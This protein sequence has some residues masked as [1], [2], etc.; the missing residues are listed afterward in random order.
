MTARS[1]HVRAGALSLPAPGVG[2][3]L[4]VRLARLFLWPVALATGGA[5]AALIVRA[6]IADAPALTA[7]VGLVVGLSWCLTG[8]EEWRRRPAR[9]IGPLML[10]FGFAWFASF[11]IYTSVS[12]LYTAG[13]LV[14]PLFIAVLGHLL[15]AFP[16]GRLE[17]RLSRAIIAAAYLD[18]T[19]VVTASALFLAPESGEVQNLG[20][21]EP[22]AALSDALRNVARGVGIALI[23]ASLL[24]LARR[25]R[26]ATPPW[27][28]AVA[29][30]LWVGAAAAAAGA[31]RLLNDGLGRPLGP[32]ELVFFVIL[33]TVPL[34]LE[35]G[36]L[37]SRLAR[38]AV[39]ELIVELGQ[40]R[41]PANLRDAL[42]RALHDPRLELGYWLPQQSRY[43][44][45]EGQPVELPGDE[46]GLVA[47]IVESEGR[48]VAALIHDAS[49]R[50]DPELVEAVCAA[51][52]L[53][54]ENERLQ[55]EL[56]AHLEEL[57]ASR[58]RIVEA[59][60]AERRRLER[61][62]HDGTQQRLVSASMA[63]GLAEATLSADPERARRI[64]D[65]S[66]RTLAAALDE[67]RELSQGIHP[68]LLTERGLGPALQELAYAAPLPIELSVPIGERLPGP[69]EAAAYYV[70]AEA[71][72]NVAKYASAN[73]ASVTVTSRNG[74]VLVE[75]RDDG[76]GGADP[77]RGSG[78]RGLADRV[79]ALGG[80][81]A[82]ESPPG[83]GTRLRAEIPCAS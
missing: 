56:R 71:L 22:N 78:L 75:V 63:L 81:L 4:V 13:Q 35:M 64:L 61:D 48:R 34:A 26:R 39:A 30:M 51:A 41:A 44:D 12:L 54:L 67:L 40:T 23:L 74:R 29:P 62:L 83:E 10:F 7:S 82:V 73:A 52:G 21:V 72:T 31:L 20:L 66:R 59:A 15:L 76:V 38:G 25:W 36:L 46:S 60:D 43:V 6:E 47:T 79:E 5:T 55:A 17:G 58:V 16:S 9:R 11:W 18:T 14:R 3:L 27:R 80:T 49:L 68:G 37:R 57:R 50:D 42:A 69:V 8:L 19:V 65:E 28:R 32:V 77:V 1:W 70:V 53:A 33:A 45:R 24:L 2:I